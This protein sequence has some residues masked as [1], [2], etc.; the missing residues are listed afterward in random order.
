MCLSMKTCD[1]VEE[2]GEQFVLLKE[3]KPIKNVFL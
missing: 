2:F 3:V 1:S